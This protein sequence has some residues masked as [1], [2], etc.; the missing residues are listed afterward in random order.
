LFKFLFKINGLD[1]FSLSIF[2]IED[3]LPVDISTIIKRPLFVV[4]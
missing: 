2:N 4:R 1:I 3:D